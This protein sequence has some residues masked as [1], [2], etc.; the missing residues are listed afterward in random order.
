M[1][2]HPSFT[3]AP[4]LSF[5]RCV[6]LNSTHARLTPHQS[7]KQAVLRR[8]ESL[9]NAHDTVVSQPEERC[10]GGSL[11]VGIQEAWLGGLGEVA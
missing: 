4:L 9:R 10:C 1:D 8:P 7:R 2:K 11:G 6:V 5:S 3:R